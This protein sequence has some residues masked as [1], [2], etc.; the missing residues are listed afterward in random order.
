M[1]TIRF[2][3][4]F[5]TVTGSRTLIDR[6]N[7][8]F[9]VDCGLFQGASPLREKNRKQIDARSRDLSAVFLTHAHLDHSGFIPRLIKDGFAGPVY[10]TRGTRELSRLILMD[11]GYLEEEAAAFA[12]ATR[13]SRHNPAIPLFTYEDAKEAMKSFHIRNRREWYTFGDHLSYRFLRA[14]HIIGASMVQFQLMVGQK[15]RLVTFS[16]DIGH[17]DTLYP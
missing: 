17:R 4:A 5:D 8:T 11:A 1:F 13:Y 14:G 12:N 7:Q 9:L 3:G 6:G 10:C 15:S 2:R 16:G